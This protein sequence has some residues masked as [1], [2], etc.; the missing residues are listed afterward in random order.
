MA[1]DL[2]CIEALDCLPFTGKEANAGVLQSFNEQN[3]GNIFWFTDFFDPEEG[4][5]L[6]EYDYKNHCWRAGRFIG[7]AVYQHNDIHYKITIKPRFGEKMLFRMLEEI[8]H[9]K[10]TASAS[11]HK[12]VTIG[13]TLLKR[14]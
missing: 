13:S 14:L 10:I 8:F 4:C 5:P 6:A 2:I 1:D 9:I 11:E 12:K 3:T 7:E